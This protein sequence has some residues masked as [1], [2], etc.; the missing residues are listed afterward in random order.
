MKRIEQKLREIVDSMEMHW[1][2]CEDRSFLLNEVLKDFD[3]EYKK[4]IGFIPNL[5]L[6]INNFFSLASQMAKAH[7]PLNLSKQSLPHSW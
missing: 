7:I 1:F 6:A 3:F 5:S 2:L 4:Y